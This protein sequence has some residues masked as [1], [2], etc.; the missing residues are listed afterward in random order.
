I[1]GQH[2]TYMTK[3]MLHLA[4]IKGDPFTK[5]VSLEKSIERPTYMGGLVKV[6]DRGVEDVKG[7]KPMPLNELLKQ[8]AL[9]K[10]G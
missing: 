2:L 5:V 1:G 10:E 7:A 3:T 8:V 6:T 4:S 9:E